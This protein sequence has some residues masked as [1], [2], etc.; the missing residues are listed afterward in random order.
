[1]DSSKRFIRFLFLN[2]GAWSLC[3]HNTLFQYAIKP[4]DNVRILFATDNFPIKQWKSFYTFNFIMLKTTFETGWITKV[5][6]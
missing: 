6:T 3:Y 4:E 2:V 1:M 5:L